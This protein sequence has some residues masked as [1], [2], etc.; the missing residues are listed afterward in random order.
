MVDSENVPLLGLNS[1][2]NRD[3][4]QKCHDLK[5]KIIR[6]KLHVYIPILII[7]LTI[8]SLISIFFIRVEPNIGD[9]VAEGTHFSADNVKVLGL[10]D[11][12]GIDLQISGTNTNNFTNI[13]DFWIRNYF[14]KGGFVIRELNLKIEELDLIV[15]D[16]TKGDEMNLG[17]IEIKPFYVDI[18]DGKSTDMD[19]FVTLWPNSKGVRGILKKILLDSGATL[20]LRGDAKVKVYVFNGFVPVSSISIPLDLEI[21]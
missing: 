3:F 5:K 17:K 9:G 6:N 20:R 11:M 13:D 10:G 7:S 4:K 16:S 2:G 1:T 8:F 18:V 14:Q 21:H 12:G 15:F 19:L